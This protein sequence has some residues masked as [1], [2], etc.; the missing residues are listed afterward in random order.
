M[1]QLPN[2]NPVPLTQQL[3]CDNLGYCCPFFFFAYFPSASLVEA[4]LGISKDTVL[5]W[6]RKARTGRIACTGSP[7]CMS[8]LLKPHP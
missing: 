2:N 6:Q 4:R 3:V 7:K 5:E 8:R 1:T